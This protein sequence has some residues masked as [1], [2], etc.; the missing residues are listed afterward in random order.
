MN[1]TETPQVPGTT[2]TTTPQHGASGVTLDKIHNRTNPVGTPDMVADP[3]CRYPWYPL[4]GHRQ[5]LRAND[6]VTLSS[7]FWLLMNEG[8]TAHRPDVPWTV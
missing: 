1:R 5:G 4:V 8:G 3:D 6:L 7:A 2:P